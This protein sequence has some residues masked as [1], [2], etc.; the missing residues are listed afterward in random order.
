[1]PELILLGES[2]VINTSLAENINRYWTSSINPQNALYVSTYHI[3]EDYVCG[4]LNPCTYYT[5]KT[6]ACNTRGIRTF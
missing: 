2:K 6:I 1:M 3:L 4:P 5:L